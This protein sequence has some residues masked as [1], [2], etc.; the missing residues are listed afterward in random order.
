MDVNTS[1]KLITIQKST[2]E[3]W[4][5]AFAMWLA[6]HSEN[7]RRNYR[8]SWNC[9]LTELGK[10]PWEIQR[11]DLARWVDSMRTRGLSDCTRNLR[12]AAVSSFY[13]YTNNDFTILVDGQEV[14]L[15]P[16]NPAAGK[17][18]RAKISPFGKARALSTE[19]TRAL[20]G[21]I[22]SACPQGQRDLAMILTYLFTGRRNSE[23]RHLRWGDITNRGDHVLYRW[24]GK[25]KADQLYE[26]PGPA[27]SAI[28]Q[29]LESAGRLGGM[30]PQEY[31]FIALSPSTG[32]KIGP[33][34]AREVG[35]I[36]KKYARAAGLNDREIH[37]HSLRHTAAMLRK[38]AGDDL[39]QISKFLAHS[40]LSITQIYLHTVEGARDESW[41]KVK[42]LLGL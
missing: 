5:E 2:A 42:A 28:R 36:L 4:A 6:G 40:S 19:E 26:L 18:L 24:S 25:G 30:G 39:E 10:M 35:R 33:L 7:T 38:E 17:S 3:T 20:I 14:P 23:I 8:D 41:A 11:T 22:P 12:M 34:S 27:W 13:S 1:S 16:Y 32:R 29:Y 15:Y 9:L 31:I 21:A 37:V